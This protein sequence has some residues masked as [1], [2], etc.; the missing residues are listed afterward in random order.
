MS[1]KEDKKELKEYF[2]EW[3]K[4]VEN[5]PYYT[6]STKKFLLNRKKNFSYNWSKEALKKGITLKSIKKIEEYLDLFYSKTNDGCITRYYNGF[7]AVGILETPT[8]HRTKGV[9]PIF[10][11]GCGYGDRWGD[12]EIRVNI[13]LTLRETEDLVEVLNGCI[14]KFK[15]INKEE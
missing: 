15:D 9:N 3:A 5:N 2:N 12:I 1:E 8:D 4:E 6:E 13:S 7:V 14:E 10:I 11:F